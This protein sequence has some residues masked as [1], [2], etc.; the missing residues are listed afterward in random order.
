MTPGDKSLSQ[1]KQCQRC[2][3][4]FQCGSGGAQGDCWCMDLPIGLPLPKAGE[5]DCFCPAC[6][7]QIKEHVLAGK[8][9]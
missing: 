3:A 4:S 2:G 8:P 7:A 6:L 5:G 1:T 9:F